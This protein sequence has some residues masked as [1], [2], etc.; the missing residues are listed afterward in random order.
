MQAYSPNVVPMFGSERIRSGL[1]ESPDAVLMRWGK[2][3]ALALLWWNDLDDDDLSGAGSCDDLTQ[4]I[5]QRL[6]RSHDEAALEV[7]RFL[8]RVERTLKAN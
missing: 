8:M 1:V 4:V 6:G 7:S 5:E 2:V 3:K